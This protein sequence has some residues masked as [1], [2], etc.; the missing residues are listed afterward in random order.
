MV[1]KGKVLDQQ[2]FLKNSLAFPLQPCH[3]VLVLIGLTL[4][5][6]VLVYR[7]AYFPGRL[8]LRTNFG[9]KD[10]AW[11]HLGLECVNSYHEMAEEFP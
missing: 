4:L 11:V 7:F 6:E 9:D 8:Q 1:Q 5:C 3:K 2:I 10:S